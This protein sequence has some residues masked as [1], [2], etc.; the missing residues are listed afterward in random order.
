MDGRQ[1]LDPVS[2]LEKGEL[3]SELTSLSTVVHSP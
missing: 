2:G 1:S 3:I